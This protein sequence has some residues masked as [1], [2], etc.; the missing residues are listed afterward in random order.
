MLARP[1]NIDRGSS[2]RSP[3]SSP[4]REGGGEGG[5]KGSTKCLLYV[6]SVVQPKAIC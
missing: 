1:Q 3:E 5:V 2:Q 4:T 6:H